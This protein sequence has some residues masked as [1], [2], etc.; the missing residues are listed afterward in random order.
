MRAAKLLV[1]LTAAA[2]VIGLA[3]P[4]QAAPADPYVHVASATDDTFLQAIDRLG[5][6]D[7]SGPEAVYIA[8]AACA[9]IQNGNGIREAVDGVRN[10]SSGLPLLKS[11]HFVAVARAI[12][13]PDT[14]DW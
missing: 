6:E 7:P 11:A 5:I 9:H 4:A 8:K 3:G 10:A 14:P 13:C 2:A 1:A 12:Y